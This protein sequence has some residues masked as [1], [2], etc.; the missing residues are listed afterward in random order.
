MKALE[1]LRSKLY[2]LFHAKHFAE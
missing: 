1:G 2:E